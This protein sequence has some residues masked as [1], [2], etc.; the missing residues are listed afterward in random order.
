MRRGRPIPTGWR[1]RI[2]SSLCTCRKS[3]HG[4]RSGERRAP[5]VE[6]F[7]AGSVRPLLVP[8]CPSPST[9]TSNWKPTPW[10]VVAV[11]KR[12]TSDSGCPKSGVV[13]GHFSKGRL[14]QYNMRQLGLVGAAVTIVG[15]GITGRSG[16]RGTL[17][18]AAGEFFLW[19][20]RSP[21]TILPGVVLPGDSGGP[22]FLELYGRS[23]GW[24]APAPL[25]AR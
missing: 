2:A 16:R 19:D 6:R 14:P 9:N 11:Q 3:T 4:L 18:S 5:C 20:P 24:G 17:R 1:N 12:R 23:P 22:T 7:Q 10:G 8:S 13:P 21:R 25:L 15:Y